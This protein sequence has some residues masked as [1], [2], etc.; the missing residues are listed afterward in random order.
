MSEETISPRPIRRRWIRLRLPIVLL[1]LV[2]IVYFC[3]AIVTQIR[4]GI[5]GLTEL[6]DPSNLQEVLEVVPNTS[7]SRV[8]L[9]GD[10]LIAVDGWPIQFNVDWHN[11]YPV[12]DS[13]ELTLQ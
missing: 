2:V 3:I 5:V 1:I 11:F 6:S 12:K 8:I 10:R 4:L 7:A 9:P 13:F